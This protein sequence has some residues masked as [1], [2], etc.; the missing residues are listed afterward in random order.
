MT[1]G[2]GGFTVTNLRKGQYAF[3][4]G[5]VALNVQEPLAG[6]DYTVSPNPAV[7]FTEVVW[8]S[9]AKVKSVRVYDSAG[10]FIESRSIAAEQTAVR[11]DVEMWSTGVYSVVLE[12]ASGKL[13]SKSFLVH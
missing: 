11:I 3:G 13:G 6:I 1:N 12:G 2:N 9:E 5:D 4:N 7:S 10:R 8:P